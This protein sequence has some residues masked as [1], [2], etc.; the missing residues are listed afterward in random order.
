MEENRVSLKNGCLKKT[1]LEL[2][3]ISI[4]LSLIYYYLI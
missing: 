3:N 4:T 2:G 1:D